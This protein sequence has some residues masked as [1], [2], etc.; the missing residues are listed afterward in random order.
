MR[1]AVRSGRLRSADGRPKPSL[2]SCAIA[3]RARRGIE[4][5]VPAAL[6]VAVGALRPSSFMKAAALGPTRG[7]CESLA[8]TWNDVPWRLP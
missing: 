6:P 7:Q 2:G 5:Q 4:T 1:R 3:E 8:T